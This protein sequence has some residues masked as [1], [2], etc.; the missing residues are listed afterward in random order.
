MADDRRWF[1][2]LHP[3]RE[4]RFDSP[5]TVAE[6]VDALGDPTAFGPRVMLDVDEFAFRLRQ[7]G[8]NLTQ[9]EI[10]LVLTETDRGTTLEGWATLTPQAMLFAGVFGAGWT[11]LALASVPGVLDGGPVGPVDPFWVLGI[12]MLLLVWCWLMVER[13]RLVALIHRMSVP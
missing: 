13:D 1:T 2:K 11:F 9:I 5:Y 12:A 7:Q 3:R 10:F 4:V 6:L 8:K